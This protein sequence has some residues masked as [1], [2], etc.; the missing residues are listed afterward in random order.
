MD[1]AKYQEVFG[2]GSNCDDKSRIVFFLSYFWWVCSAHATTLMHLLVQPD[3]PPTTCHHPNPAEIFIFVPAYWNRLTMKYLWL[4]PFHMRVA[5][6]IAGG[7]TDFVA[8]ASGIQFGKIVSCKSKLIVAS[9]PRGLYH[10][11]VALLFVTMTQ[12]T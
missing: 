1:N 7:D 2:L 5:C 11:R 10:L 9:H 4:G 6:V 12:T 8:A 3:T